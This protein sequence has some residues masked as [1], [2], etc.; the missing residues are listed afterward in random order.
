MLFRSPKQS[1]KENSITEKIK[2]SNVVKGVKK[3]IRSRLPQSGSFLDDKVLIGIGILLICTGSALFIK[4]K[5][6]GWK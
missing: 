3:S 6:K 1:L 4:K 2:S 5:C